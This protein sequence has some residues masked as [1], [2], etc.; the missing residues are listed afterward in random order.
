MTWDVWLLLVAQVCL[1]L[2][3]SLWNR[4]ID[5][6]NKALAIQE[7]FCVFF[8]FWIGPRRYT[9]IPSFPSNTRNGGGNPIWTLSSMQFKFQKLSNLAWNCQQRKG[10]RSHPIIL[11]VSFKFLCRVYNTI[12][13]R[14]RSQLRFWRRNPVWLLLMISVIMYI[15][16]FYLRYR[17]AVYV[18]CSWKVCTYLYTFQEEERK[19]QISHRKCK[20]IIAFK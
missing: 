20:Y 17:S 2:G 13:I 4:K 18:F 8:I 10:E 11:F 14:G 15:L 16:Y 12:I 7:R 3:S 9:L 5:C 1:C 6:S 19:I